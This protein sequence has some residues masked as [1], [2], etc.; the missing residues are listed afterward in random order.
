MNISKQ[1]EE[2]MP[3]KK[4]INSTH[5]P[6]INE[7]MINSIM[8]TPTKSPKPKLFGDKQSSSEFEEPSES[9]EI[10]ESQLTPQQLEQLRTD[11]RAEEI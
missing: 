2:N 1:I 5:Q 8:G 7:E 4:I 9:D 10:D 6:T 11:K 3:R